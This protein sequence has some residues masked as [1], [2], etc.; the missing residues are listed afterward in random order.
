ME[1]DKEY[2][3]LETEIKD[4]EH[5]KEIDANLIIVK[6]YITKLT[7]KQSKIEG[8]YNHRL[9]P[10]LIRKEE[11]LTGFKNLY[12]GTKKK[13]FGLLMLSYRITKSLKVLDPT[14]VVETLQ[15]I[16]KVEEGVKS[17]DLIFLRKLADA[18]VFSEDVIN[19]DEKVN[20]KVV[21]VK[22]VNEK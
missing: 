9:Q 21:E 19:F 7:E 10:L 2:I 1:P 18:N 22:K 12:D 14:G 4:I 6:D 15:K 8:I 11:L 13:Q 5:Q 3:G 17:F 20:V 16:G